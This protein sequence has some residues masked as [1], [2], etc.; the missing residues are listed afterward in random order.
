MATGQQVLRSFWSW[1]A[2]WVLKGAGLKE[3]G[4]TLWNSV[5]RRGYLERHCQI[6]RDS[7][8]EDRPEHKTD[9]KLQ[10]A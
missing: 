8:V 7:K 10:R 9:I 3:T 2:C 4:V 1:G 5:L 6:G